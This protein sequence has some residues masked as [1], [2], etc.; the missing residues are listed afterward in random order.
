M[1]LFLVLG[2]HLLLLH[3]LLLIH[4]VIHVLL[5]LHHHLLLL[6]LVHLI[7]V[8]RLL[9]LHLLLHAMVLGDLLVLGHLARSHFLPRCNLILRL[10]LSIFFDL[11]TF[12]C[13][14]CMFLLL[15]RGALARL[16]FSLLSR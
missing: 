15:V 1:H 2:A 10:L 7:H 16:H 9:L 13:F 11:I 8:V 5:L 12:S 3:E 4:L 14:L 6:L